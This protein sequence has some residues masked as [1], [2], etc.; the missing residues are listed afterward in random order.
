MR[1]G[2]LVLVALLAGCLGDVLEDQQL[3]LDSLDDHFGCRDLDVGAVSGDASM[4]LTVSVDDMLM[5]QLGDA[6]LE[7]SY[8]LPDDRVRVTLTTGENLGQGRCGRASVGDPVQDGID[9]GVSGTVLV[10]VRLDPDTDEP[11]AT[12][13]LEDVRFE[14]VE[15][16]G[17]G[18]SRY[19]RLDA[20]AFEAQPLGLDP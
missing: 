19:S 12:V 7:V 2:L 9:R 4:M 17:W 20:F 5:D 10:E 15:G 6:P 18:L 11:W 3:E 13:T 1:F 16:E 8:E 14:H